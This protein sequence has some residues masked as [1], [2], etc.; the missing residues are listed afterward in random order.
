MQISKFPSLLC[1]TKHEDANADDGIFA[2]KPTYKCLALVNLSLF[3]EIVWEADKAHTPRHWTA[4]KEEFLSDLNSNS[5]PQLG[6]N[7]SKTRF[8]GSRLL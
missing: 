1:N 3:R 8:E 7:C 4:T 2:T 5:E 6:T